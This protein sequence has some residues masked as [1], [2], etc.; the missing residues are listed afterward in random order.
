MP[1]CPF[2]RAAQSCLP[3]MLPTRRTCSVPF[4]SPQPPNYL[5]SRRTC[6][7]RGKS[8]WKRSSRGW[9]GAEVPAMKLTG[10]VTP[11]TP[12]SSPSLRSAPRD[13]GAAR[14][15]RAL[16]SRTSSIL[17]IPTETHGW[18]LQVPF[19]SEANIKLSW[20]GKF[21]YEFMCRSKKW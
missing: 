17:S 13:P 11:Q 18:S 15:T 5:H 14:P 16:F 9:R 10:T 8:C 20:R 7:R 6:P 12:C 1:A 21:R 4:P 19:T 3:R 2:N